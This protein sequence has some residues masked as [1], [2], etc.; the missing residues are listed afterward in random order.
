MENKREQIV[1]DVEKE[2]AV[3]AE[4]LDSYDSLSDIGVTWIVER[5]ADLERKLER[6]RKG[7]E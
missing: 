1:F 5:L 7:E 6:F 2:L 4:E 3:L